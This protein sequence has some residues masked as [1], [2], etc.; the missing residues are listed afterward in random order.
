MDSY[1]D[2]DGTPITTEKFEELHSTDGYKR[3]ARD[4]LPDG[5]VVSTVWLGL[6]HRTSD[7]GDP[8]IF[9]T[10][11]FPAEDNFMDIDCKRYTNED[12]AIDGH[13]EVVKVWS[14]M[15]V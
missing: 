6:D 14:L 13:I 12:D 9:E 10:M 2:K 15:S 4:V 5:K 11:V 1:F 7:S 8:V 3:I